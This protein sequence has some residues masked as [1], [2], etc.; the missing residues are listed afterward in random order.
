MNREALNMVTSLYPPRP[1]LDREGKPLT[2]AAARAEGYT[3]TGE[4]SRQSGYISRRADI[5]QSAVYIAGK[6][7]RA[8][9]FYYLAPCRESTRFSWRVYLG[10]GGTKE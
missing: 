4:L 7:S 6:G 10:K 2:L 8:G 9:Q 1:A 5:E 3:E